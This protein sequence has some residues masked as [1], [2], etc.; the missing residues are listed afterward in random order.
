M[1]VGR[2][3]RVEQQQRRLPA[4][5]VQVQDDAA[6]LIV[7]AK[8]E[9]GLARDVLQKLGVEFEEE[10]FVRAGLQHLHT[11]VILAAS[12]MKVSTK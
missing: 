9:T 2:I 7:E 8:F 6:R 3:G 1:D 12:M 4:F 10:K 11:E 5:G